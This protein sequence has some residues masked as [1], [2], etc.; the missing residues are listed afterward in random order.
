MHFY[1]FYNS[2]LEVLSS[3]HLFLMKLTGCLNE[4]YH[5]A[6]SLSCKVRRTLLSLPDTHLQAVSALKSV[7]FE[8]TVCSKGLCPDNLTLAKMT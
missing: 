4:L 3:Y 6:K 8:M 2:N 1:M 5:T 7:S